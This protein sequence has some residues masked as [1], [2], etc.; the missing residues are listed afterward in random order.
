[1]DIMNSFSLLLNGAW[2]TLYISGFSMVFGL[3]LGTVI[4]LMRVSA[5]KYISVPAGVYVE[6]LRGTPLLVQIFLI[7]FG[8][9]AI[10]MDIPS[11]IAA[12]LALSINSSAYIAEIVRSG[13]QSVDKGQFTASTSLG[14]SYFQTMINIILPQAFRNTLPTIGNEFIALI[15]ESSLISVIGIAELTRQGQFIISRTFMSFEIYA[16]VALIYF[17][18]TFSVSRI[19]KAVEKRMAIA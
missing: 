14:F 17:V 3:V 7:Y 2:I 16:G 15:K 19:F 8:L 18:M 5:K 13:I 11:N 9:P 6:F 10:G 1:M 4:G 12:V